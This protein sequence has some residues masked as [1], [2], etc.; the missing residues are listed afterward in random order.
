VPQQPPTIVA[1]IWIVR[2]AKTSKYSGV[3]I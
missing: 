3:A 1:P 2:R